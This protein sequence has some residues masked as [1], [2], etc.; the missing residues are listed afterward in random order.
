VWR[1]GSVGKHGADED[2]CSSPQFINDSMK[3]CDAHMLD[4]VSSRLEV[5][6]AIVQKLASRAKSEECYAEYGDTP[7]N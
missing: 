4:P 5:G 6:T 1:F 2:V 7:R 3:A